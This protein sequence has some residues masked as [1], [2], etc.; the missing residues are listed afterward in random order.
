MEDKVSSIASSNSPVWILVP[1]ML[2]VSA[3]GERCCDV[4]RYEGIQTEQCVFFLR[5]D[6]R[7]CRFPDELVAN[8]QPG[9]ER[10][11]ACILRRAPVPGDVC[12]SCGVLRMHFCFFFACGHGRLVGVLVATLSSS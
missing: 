4:M 1:A 9:V 6:A 12:P 10:S 5:G 8:L 11:V 3:M 7:N 2:A